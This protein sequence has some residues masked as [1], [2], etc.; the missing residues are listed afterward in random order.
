MYT[1]I[2]K[3]KIDSV[4]DSPYSII[5]YIATVFAFAIIPVLIGLDLCLLSMIL[6]VLAILIPLKFYKEPKLK[7]VVIA[8]AIS[9]V[10]IAAVG[11]IF[12][13][14]LLYSQEPTILGSDTLVNGTVDRIYGDT[15]TVFNFTVEVPV[16]MNNNYTTYVNLT[17]FGDDGT[18]EQ[19]I[20]GEMRLLN[21][22]VHYWETLLDEKQYFYHF[23]LETNVGNE[24]F[25]ESTD[26]GFGPLV[27]PKNTAVVNIFIMRLISPFIIFIIFASLVWWK[28]GLMDSR[29]SSIEGLEEK[30]KALEDSCPECGALLEGEDECPDCD[31]NLKEED[32]IVEK[33]RV[34]CPDCRHLIVSD[35]ESC[36]YCGTDLEK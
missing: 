35:N 15:E 4:R 7:K 31:W 8:G 2:L 29:G 36:P 6:S 10:L 11:T 27:I 12:H 23:S 9:I 24:T 14:H 25:W 34:K 5:V 3:Q 18:S 28:K 22:N 17:Y 19:N 32:T 20:T 1:T 21:D 30:E 33:D 13:V 16:E 26:K